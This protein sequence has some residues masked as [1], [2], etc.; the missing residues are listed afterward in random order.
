MKGERLDGHDY[1]AAAL[2][3]GAVAA[4]VSMRWL[5]PAEVD[6]TKLL[7]VPDVRGLRVECAAEA[8]SCGA[9]GVG[10]AGDWGDGVGGED[11]DEGDGGAGFG[12]EV[13][14]AEVGGEFE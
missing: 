9:E 5:V 14:G 10:W 4:V 11:D 6:E 7:R 12:G 13:Q 8:G 1:V 3:D 2:A